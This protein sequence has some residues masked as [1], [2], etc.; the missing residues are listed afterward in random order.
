MEK[1]IKNYIDSI[2]PKNI[3][4][5]RKKSISDEFES[6]IYEKIDF[7]EEIGYTKE[8]SIKKALEEM[9]ESEEIRQSICDDFNELY[10]EKM[11]WP[12]GVGVG[13]LLMNLAFG[14][15][16]CWVAGIEY[17]GDPHWL[18]TAA[19]VIMIFI[20]TAVFLYAIKRR[21]IST[22]VSIAISNFLIG[23]SMLWCFYPQTAIWSAYYNLCYLIDKFTPVYAF[24]YF[25]KADNVCFRGSIIF[26][27]VVSIFCFVLAIFVEDMRR[28]TINK[29]TKVIGLTAVVFSVATCILHPLSTE[30]RDN[31]KKWFDVY[32]SNISAKSM[33]VYNL[34]NEAE[35]YDEAVSILKS[36]NYISREEF[37]KTTDRNTLKR[38]RA[39]MNDFNFFDNTYEVWFNTKEHIEGN[40]FIFIKKDKN[41]NLA[42]YGIGNGCVMF[43]ADSLDFGVSFIGFNQNDDMQNI[44]KE[45]KTL[46]VGDKENDVMSFFG[47]EQGSVYTIF[48][49]KDDGKTNNYY[50]VR[51]CNYDSDEDYDLYKE[52]YIELTFEDGI[53]T[54]GCLYSLD[55]DD[56]Y[57]DICDYNDILKIIPIEQN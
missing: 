22:I 45:F 53:L 41:N 48:T 16:G 15:A 39:S 35:S 49:E 30:Y 1:E 27:I 4:K 23:I 32:N 28:K 31:Y 54:D 34:L 33:S 51:C 56:Y 20:I 29:I 26:L 18:Q 14:F 25:D 9:G 19:S 52:Y 21:Y 38:F 43:E 37:E 11:W 8:Q 24:D 50:R 2:I 7:Y 57:N 10:Y 42:A 44:M 12:F 36:E 46:K 13:I 3:S 5:S 6:H 40:G 55:Y 47:K 17:M